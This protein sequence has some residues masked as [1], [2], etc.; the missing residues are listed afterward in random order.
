MILPPGQYN[1]VAEIPNLGTYQEKLSIKD[2]KLFKPEISRNIRINF[3]QD[4]EQSH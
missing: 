3:A 2:R 1:L 4:K